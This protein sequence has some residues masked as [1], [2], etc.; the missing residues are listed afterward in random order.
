[1]TNFER[2]EMLLREAA[3]CLSEMESAFE[4]QEWNMVIRRAQEVVELC[5]KAI[6]KVLSVEYPKVHEVSGEFIRICGQKKVG[7]SAADG[8]RIATT[9]KWL[10]EKRSSAFYYEQ[11]FTQ[12]EAQFARDGAAWVYSKTKDLAE[13]LK[14]H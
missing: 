4:S 7:L 10:A 12:E 8:D 11:L 14:G 1:M 13:L 2:G 9:S 6:F 3:F 5:L